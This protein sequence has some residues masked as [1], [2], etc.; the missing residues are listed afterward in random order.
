MDNSVNQADDML[1]RVSPEGRD[2][3]RRE[4]EE[5]GRRATN[6]IL[7]CL[8]WGILLAAFGF[9]ASVVGL[10]IPGVLPLL[11]VLFA[12]GCGVILYRGRLRPVAAGSLAQLPLAALPGRAGEWL[13]GQRA[14][15]PAPAQ[16]LAD[17]LS[18][19][20]ASL[21]PQLAS[22]EAH[23]ASSLAQSF[24]ISFSVSA[25]CRSDRRQLMTP[26]LALSPGLGSSMPR[27]RASP[28]ISPAAPLT[29]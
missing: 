7:M 27:S 21:G 26:K 19:K 4:R 23:F 17:A 12:A 5:R 18:R 24:L 14:A 10:R 20:L 9:A 2:R 15:L 6:L 3:A 25:V 8:L 29:L 22:I 28:T 13:E 11:L 1:R 16:T